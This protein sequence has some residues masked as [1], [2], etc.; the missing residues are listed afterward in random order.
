MSYEQS[1][2]FDEWRDRCGEIAL[3]LLDL[4]DILDDGDPYD[5]ADAMEDAY[6]NGQEP[7]AFIRE[8]FAEDLSVRQYD[9]QLLKESDYDDEDDEED[10]DEW[11]ED[12]DEDDDDED[13]EDDDE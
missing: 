3:D 12:D 7:E 2:T 4:D 8:A 1:L 6:E 11:N 10:D 9:D 13:E 5:L